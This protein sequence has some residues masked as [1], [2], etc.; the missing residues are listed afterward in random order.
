[1]TSDIVTRMLSILVV[2]DDQPVLHTVAD[3]V[4]ALGHACFRAY[5][6]EEALNIAAQHLIQA[7]I[8][9]LNIGEDDGLSTLRQ[10]LRLNASLRAVLM[11][12]ALTDE[13]R[14]EAGRLGVRRVLDKPLNLEDLRGAVY[15]LQ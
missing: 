11:S 14:A 13:V 12:G 6:V 10:L 1:M 5:S 9:D 4:E 7:T 15:R 2:D 3:V 8:L